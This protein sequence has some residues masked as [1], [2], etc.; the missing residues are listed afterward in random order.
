V[1]ES[2]LVACIGGAAGLVLSMWGVR[3]LV[4]TAPIGRIPR[5]GEITVDWRVL[6]A[7]FGVSLV[8]GLACGIFPALASTRR[9]PRAAL[10]TSGRTVAGT[11]DRLRRVFVVAQLALAIV[12]LSGAG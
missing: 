12:L 11:H 4:A 7:A 6:G 5:G 9:D 10:T 1:T 2:A 3:V 8:A